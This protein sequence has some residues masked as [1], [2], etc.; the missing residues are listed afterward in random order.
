MSDNR[1]TLADDVIVSLSFPISEDPYPERRITLNQSKPSVQVGRTSKRV[2]NLAAA[3]DNGWLDSPVISREHAEIFLGPEQEKAV[4][5]KDRHSRHGTFVNKDRICPGTSVR[6]QRG[7]FVRFGID[8]Q[9][10]QGLFPPPAASIDIQFVDRTDHS[11]TGTHT[12]ADRSVG[13]HAPDPCDDSDALDS[14]DCDEEGRTAVRSA[15]AILRAAGEK[16]APKVAADIGPH[17]STSLE[18]DAALSQI[19][20]STEVID[21]DDYEPHKQTV[22]DLTGASIVHQTPVIP[23]PA[24]AIPEILN[25]DDDEGE[26]GE[27][28]PL[29]SGERR[30]DVYCGH[31]FDFDTSESERESSDDDPQRVVAPLGI[32]SSSLHA[33]TEHSSDDDEFEA[34]SNDLTGSD[35]DSI[36]DGDEFD[37][38]R[39]VFVAVGDLTNSLVPRSSGWENYPEASRPVEGHHEIDDLP[40]IETEKG[41]V[42][43]S[44]QGHQ[45]LLPSLQQVLG[46][47]E[48]MM[49]TLN[50]IKPKDTPFVSGSAINSRTSTLHNLPPWRDSPICHGTYPS[51]QSPSTWRSEHVDFLKARESN[52]QELRRRVSIS[53][54]EFPKSSNTLL[55]TTITEPSLPSAPKAEDKLT[56]GHEHASSEN[57]TD[58]DFDLTPCANNLDSRPTA[59]AENTWETSGDRFLAG[60]PEDLPI[61]DVRHSPELDMTS[62]WSFQVSKMAA[63]TGDCN[64]DTYAPETTAEFQIANTIAEV[65]EEALSPV[66]VKRKASEISD[67]SPDEEAVGTTPVISTVDGDK[68]AVK[69][70]FEDPVHDGQATLSSAETLN[71]NKRCTLGVNEHDC[72][73]SPKRLRR[74]AEAAGLVALGGAAAGVAFITT[75]IATAPAL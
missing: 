7:D 70:P 32:W 42:P 24:G 71:L 57:H 31:P 63:V 74:M 59:P 30:S 22:I 61:S 12:P 69:A 20:P 46:S 27:G 66:S 19:N 21:L 45:W 5:I 51:T 56:S 37:T 2:A 47:D 28:A 1:M 18:H 55:S 23:H 3:L 41:Q 13:Y 52:K 49:P 39:K 67:L 73:R 34:E 53:E 48:I 9:R 14:D 64:S 35:K 54:M 44:P 10:D 33:S 17:P 26:E 6:L 62:A 15:V 16:R 25:V 60:P 75:L 40:A 11:T 58:E 68:A 50:P 29:K 65:G 43:P 38:N 36:S 72:G 4:Y 8:I